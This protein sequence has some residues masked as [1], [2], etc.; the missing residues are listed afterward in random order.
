MHEHIKKRIEQIIANLD[1]LPSLPVVVTKIINM[2]ND[3]EVDFKKVA[4]EISHD[5]AITA[6]ILRICNSAYYSKGKEIASVDRAIVTLGIKEVK[7]I[8]VI[9]TTKQ[10]LNKPIIGYDLDKGDLWKHNLLVAMLAKKMALDKK[11]RALSDTIFTGGII[12]DVGKTVLAM[13][14]ANTFKDIIALS[15]EQHI[16]F[17]NAEHEIMGF[18]HTE[19]GEKVLT[20]WQFPDVLRSIVRFHHEPMSAP[21]PHREAVSFVHVANSIC[22]M[23]GIGIGSDGLYHELNEEAVN[24]IGYTGPELEN[25][26]AH[27]PEILKQAKDM[28]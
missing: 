18:D 8:V 1:Q 19:I 14:V 2:V 17:T 5:Q 3:P 10:I 13:F 23:A 4:D 25:L 9:S 27:V 7:D 12:H 22:L 24:I 16:P 11:K 21:Q 20:K 15:Q 6:D 28:L 26:Y